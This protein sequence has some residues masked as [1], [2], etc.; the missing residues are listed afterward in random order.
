V[1]YIDII[2][3]ALLA[4][5]VLYRLSRVLGRRPD[6]SGSGLLR[7]RNRRDDNIVS[8]PGRSPVRAAPAPRPA[9]KNA[10]AGDT[11][12]DAGVA[13]VR[14]SDP[15]FDPGQFL[16]GARAAYEMIVTAYAKGDRETLRNLLTRDVFDNF[17]RAVAEREQRGETLETTVVG[18]RKVE[19]VEERMAGRNAEV[20]VR[21][22]SDLINTI[23]DRTGQPKEDGAGSGVKEVID[24]WT[25]VRDTRSR[26]PNW[27]LAETRSPA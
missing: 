1:Q 27:A 4:A 12:T 18:I 23:R 13:E 20:T 9:A 8:L 6:D 16:A 21:F 19:I 17:A 11:L 2:L 14:L 22:V 10:D 7:P 3:L 15:T 24:T 26:D 5:F 25:F